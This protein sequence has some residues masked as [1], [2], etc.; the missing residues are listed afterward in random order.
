MTLVINA[1]P[2]SNDRLDT[3]VPGGRAAVSS[4]QLMNVI[5]WSRDIAG[6]VIF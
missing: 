6:R 5:S 4:Q 2:L 1:A 3:S